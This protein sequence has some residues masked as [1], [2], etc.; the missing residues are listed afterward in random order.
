VI[1]GVAN[2]YNGTTS[3]NTLFAWNASTFALIKTLDVSSVQSAREMA[4]D[5]Q[6]NLYFS[7]YAG[8]GSDDLV[9]CFAGGADLANWTPAIVSTNLSIVLIDTTYAPYT[10]LDVACGAGVASIPGD[11]NNDGSVDLA[12]YTVWADNFG[13]TGSGIAGDGN[14]DGTVDLADYTIWADHF[15]QTR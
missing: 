7:T 2:E 4:F 11:Y 13:Q 9:A 5:Y 8:S 3:T 14:N 10:G 6:G 15:G 1:Y 12:D